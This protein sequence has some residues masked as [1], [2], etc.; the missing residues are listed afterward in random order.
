MVEECMR[1]V[2]QRNDT[3][4]FV[5]LH[6]DDAE[7]EE[8]GVPAVLAYKGGDKFAGL[9]PLLNELPD[10]SELS[11][12]ALET[13]FRRSVSLPLRSINLRCEASPTSNQL[14]NMPFQTPHSINTQH[15]GCRPNPF[16]ANRPDTRFQ[17]LA[18]VRGR[19]PA[20]FRTAGAI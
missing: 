5:K 14:T 8:E 13:A 17:V 15:H 6:N 3:V 1:Q 19:T 20:R 7:M 12:V 16:F 18:S 4:R 11:A 9:V 10:D 2:A